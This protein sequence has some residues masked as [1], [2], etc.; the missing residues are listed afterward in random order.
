MVLELTLDFSIEQ[1]FLPLESRLWRDGGMPI[2][3]ACL[4]NTALQ[5]IAAG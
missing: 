5:G 2:Y 1:E 3:R 4:P